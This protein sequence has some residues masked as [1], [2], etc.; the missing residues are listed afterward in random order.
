MRKVAA[1]LMLA[2]FL[3]GC[4]P[5][6]E[7]PAP[8]A[9]EWQA[10]LKSQEEEI[11]RLEA[12][13]DRLRA[14]CRGSAAWEPESAPPPPDLDALARAEPLPA[15]ARPQQRPDRGTQAA[16]PKADPRRVAEILSTILGPS[17]PSA[18]NPSADSPSV[19]EG[20]LVTLREPEVTYAQPG[21]LGV[22]VKVWNPSYTQS[23]SRTATLQLFDGG[24]LIDQR[25]LYL[26]A[27][28]PQGEQVL[29]ETFRYKFTDDV[30][31]V[32]SARLVYE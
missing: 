23:V 30:G 17:A 3:T 1:A 7:P 22:E 18:S 12:E 5:A 4:Q 13:V 32:F 24:K 11:H 31:A 9:P 6:K 19:G 21:E 10:L 16:A 26:E 29:S 15:G 2:L 28:P 20:R 14:G 25:T 27:I 8:P